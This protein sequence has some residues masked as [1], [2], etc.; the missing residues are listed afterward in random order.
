LLNKYQKTFNEFFGKTSQEGEITYIP[1]RMGTVLNQ[2]KTEPITINTTED[3]RAEGED[4]QKVRDRS[5]SIRFINEIL[6]SCTDS[7]E[8]PP[9]LFSSLKKRI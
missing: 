3:D 7:E 9:K 1:T 5:D 6:K 8:S 4:I 2:N